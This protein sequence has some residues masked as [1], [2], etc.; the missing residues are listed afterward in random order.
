MGE[1]FAEATVRERLQA[2]IDPPRAVQR[3]EVHR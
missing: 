1:V 2:A 3:T